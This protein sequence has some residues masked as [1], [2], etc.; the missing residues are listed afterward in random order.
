ML[1]FLPDKV[2]ILFYIQINLVKYYSNKSF[3]THVKSV[4]LLCIDI[5]VIDCAACIAF[6]NIPWYITLPPTRLNR[7]CVQK[8]YVLQWFLTIYQNRLAISVFAHRFWWN[9]HH[10][11]P[12][13]FTTSSSA[14]AVFHQQ[15]IFKQVHYSVPV[16]WNTT[17]KRVLSYFE[18]LFIAKGGKQ[19]E[20]SKRTYRLTSI[21]FT[22]TYCL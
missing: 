2:V 12:R 19:S 4:G 17:F 8:M 21:S 20:I 9:F 5:L 1:I 16:V 11:L 3:Y 7:L 15:E 14:T 13:T 18:P 10:I 22:H 6:Y